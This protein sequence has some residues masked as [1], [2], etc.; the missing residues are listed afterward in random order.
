MPD[1]APPTNQADHA[2]GRHR[3]APEIRHQGPGE[4][5]PHAAQPRFPAP[6]PALIA[7]AAGL[8]AALL[9]YPF[10]GPI[11]RA[12]RSAYQSPGLGGDLRRAIETLQQFGDLPTTL[13]LAAVI[14]LL[15]PTR[16][17]RLLD[18]LAAFLLNGLACQ[19]LKMALGRPRPSLN[20]PATIPGPFGA[21]PLGVDTAPDG[22]SIPLGV[23]HGWELTAPDIS[24]LWSMP[25]SH[26]ATAAAV[27]TALLVL[28]PRLR[29]LIVP[30]IALVACARVLVGAHWLSDTLVGA[31]I[32]VA[33]G[34]LAT[35]RY[36]GTR[37][38]DVVWHTVVDRRATPAFPALWAAEAA[39]ARSRGEIASG[40]G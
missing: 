40:P 23:R 5:T 38:L 28:Y 20:D 17:R 9:V 19:L 22:S 25:S 2:H 35:T 10:D 14:W 13:L 29:G 26:T 24:S 33:I 34:W 12:A 11:S 31:G 36:W 1:H 6:A 8:A 15:D 4:N 16:R 30:L 21:Y 37:G 27:G 39:R 32:G 7:L 18:L 3:P